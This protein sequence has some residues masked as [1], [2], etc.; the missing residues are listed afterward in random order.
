MLSKL[1]ARSVLNRGITHSQVIAPML[2]R[3]QVR[4]FRGDFVNPYLHNPIELTEK[5]RV[6][7]ESAPVWERAFDFKKYMEHD[8]PLKV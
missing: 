7:Q 8:G 1:I 3:T 5:E 4:S 6:Q 2:V